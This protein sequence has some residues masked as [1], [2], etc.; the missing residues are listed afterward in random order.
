MMSLFFSMT[1]EMGNMIRKDVDL[2][3]YSSSVC[4]NTSS[5]VLVGSLISVCA[6][7][8]LAIMIK[9]SQLYS[10]LVKV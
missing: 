1:F 9:Y 10:A 6:V 8:G 4:A 5:P 3:E 7:T 2:Y